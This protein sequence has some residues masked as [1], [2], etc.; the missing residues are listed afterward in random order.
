MARTTLPKK[1]KKKKKRTIKEILL[2]K[3][4]Q[5]QQIQN[6]SVISNWGGMIVNPPKN[7]SKRFKAPDGG[8]WTDVG[9]CMT[10]CEQ[11]CERY[12]WFCKSSDLQ[13]AAEWKNCGVQN[14]GFG[15]YSQENV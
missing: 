9:R 4:N 14:F 6:R 11:K 13:K 12:E 2:K 7:C 8:I 10:C 5:E 3:L 1:K 15:A